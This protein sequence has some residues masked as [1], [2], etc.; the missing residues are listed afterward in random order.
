M[1]VTAGQKCATSRQALCTEKAQSGHRV[2]KY[3]DWSGAVGDPTAAG[4]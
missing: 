3:E 1:P 2:N 4:A